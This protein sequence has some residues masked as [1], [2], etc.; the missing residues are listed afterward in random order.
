MEILPKMIKQSDGMTPMFDG[1][2]ERRRFQDL[3]KSDPKMLVVYYE[4]SV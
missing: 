4:V 2:D 1:I 3:V